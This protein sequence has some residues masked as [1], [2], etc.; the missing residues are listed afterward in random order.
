MLS[1]RVFILQ[2]SRLKCCWSCQYLFKEE[3][4]ISLIDT[5]DDEGPCRSWSNSVAPCYMRLD[6][7]KFSVLRGVEV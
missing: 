1:G 7:D 4:R 2:S 3:V 5:Y 6:V